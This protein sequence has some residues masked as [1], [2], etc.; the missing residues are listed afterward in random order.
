M[1]ALL[2]S[3]GVGAVGAQGAL[4]VVEHTFTAEKEI[5][6]LTG[7]QT[8]VHSIKL[9]AGSVS[10]Q[11]SAVTFAGTMAGA[12]LDRIRLRPSYGSCILGLETPASWMNTGCDYIVDSDTTGGNLAISCEPG[13]MMDFTVAGCRLQV[14]DVD[15]KGNAVNQALNGVTFVASGSG[16]TADLTATFSVTGIHYESTGPLCNFLGYPVGTTTYTNGDISGSVTLKGYEDN[17]GNEGAQAGIAF[18]TP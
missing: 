17:G 5:T 7:A 14:R 1:L 13:A 2:A 16:A 18:S 11:C 15:S 6:V 9:T 8:G 4:G 10:L 3:I 12:S